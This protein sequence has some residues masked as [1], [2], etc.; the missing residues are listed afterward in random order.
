MISSNLV[1]RITGRV[2]RL[3]AVE[4][5]GDIK[6]DLS[7]SIGVIGAVAHYSALGGVFAKLVSR[8]QAMLGLQGQELCAARIEKWST[9]DGEGTGVL[10]H[11]GLESLGDLAPW[12]LKKPGSPGI[13]SRLP[14]EENRVARSCGI[15]YT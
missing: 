7:I 3:F 10:L 8:R 14:V 13:R 12:L 6:R 2:S 11:H 4:N 5:P 9:P 15:P 1:G